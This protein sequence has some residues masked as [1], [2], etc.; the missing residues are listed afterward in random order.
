MKKMWIQILGILFLLTVG[1]V[2]YLV[3]KEE[4]EIVRRPDDLT[5]KLYW[6]SEDPNAKVSRVELMNFDT[7]KEKEILVDM[8]FKNIGWW[9]VFRKEG[10]ARYLAQCQRNQAD[11]YQYADSQLTFLYRMDAKEGDG[12]FYADQDEVYY[13]SYTP[14]GVAIK[15]YQREQNSTREIVD[16]FEEIRDQPSVYQKNILFSGRKENDVERVYFLNDQGQVQVITEGKHPQWMD[17]S[18]F[19]YLSNDD[20]TMYQ[21]DL[22]TNQKQVLLAGLKEKGI[23]V[24]GDQMG[25][26]PD[27]KYLAYIGCYSNYDVRM[28]PSAMLGELRIVSL[29]T[30][31]NYLIKEAHYG[32]LRTGSL[33]WE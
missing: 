9:Y 7:S 27:K 14:T 5:G 24:Y 6:I 12:I 26:S 13:T 32:T 8:Q 20:Q 11:I 4:P 2:L 18:T 22:V 19:L 21:Y 28:D 15:E 29:E 31:E 23:Y 30:G 1:I 16:G 17:E 33:L 3:L 10:S 25:V